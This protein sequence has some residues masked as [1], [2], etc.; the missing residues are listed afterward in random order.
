M[1][2]ASSGGRRPASAGGAA[3]VL[4]FVLCLFPASTHAAPV[5]AEMRRIESRH[6][7]I[8]TDLE[9]GFADDLAKRMDAMYDEY[10]RRLVDFKP[11][12]EMPRL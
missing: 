3:L 4:A 6:Y 9:S 12:N 1:S 8:W 11:I 10:S 7:N 5:S 2:R